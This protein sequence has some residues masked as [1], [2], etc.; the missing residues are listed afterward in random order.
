LVLASGIPGAAQ[1]LPKIPAETGCFKVIFLSRSKDIAAEARARKWFEVRAD[2][3]REALAFLREHNVL[4]KQV[5]Y[6][7]DD[8]L[9]RVCRETT[10][11]IL[12]VTLGTL[13]E[14]PSSHHAPS[15][16][17]ADDGSPVVLTYASLA[18]DLAAG[19]DSELLKSAECEL[20]SRV[21]QVEN[22]ELPTRVCFK[23]PTCL[24]FVV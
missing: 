22:R 7:S 14:P 17:S 4:Y 18:S 5:Q 15:T 12:E 1:C 8:E 3:L 10:D 11:G 19:T 24:N 9:S 23:K 16:T 21:K 13:P 20:Q 6:L 2:K